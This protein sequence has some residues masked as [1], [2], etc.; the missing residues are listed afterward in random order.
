MAVQTFRHAPMLSPSGDH[1]PDRLLAIPYNAAL[2][3]H[4][5]AR[6]MPGRSISLDNRF[7]SLTAIRKRDPGWQW[8]SALVARSALVRLDRAMQGFFSRVRPG[9]E[10][11]F[12][13]FRARSRYRSLSVDVP[14][15][16]GSALR[17]R[18]GG[19]RG[20]L[21]GRDLPRI[22]FG[23]RQPLR[24]PVRL[25]GFRAVCEARRV[26]IQLSFE[27]VLPTVRTGAPERPLG[28][29]AGTQSHATLSDGGGVERQRKPAVRVA[30]GR[31]QR[32]LSQKWRD[33]KGRGAKKAAPAR[34]HQR[35]AESGRQQFH[36]R[37]DQA[38]KC[39]DSIAAEPLRIRYTIRNTIRSDENERGLKRAP[40]EEGRG[41]FFDTLNCKDAYAGTPFVEVPPPG[42]SE[43]CSRCG[44]RVP[45]ALS[46]RVHRCGGCG[47]EMDRDES[48][49]RN[50][51]SPGRRMFEEAMAAGGTAE[52]A[53]AASAAC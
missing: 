23:V 17:I 16:A 19:R 2:E 26:E 10:S 4:I 41:E 18:D 12:P 20:A 37:T 35:V 27:R 5:R 33:S 49:A 51:L 53:P 15:A 47:L 52:R 40:A 45:K 36:R 38:V 39:G 31:K 46:E 8:I 7:P 14:K 6:R 11:G 42:T 1:L 29:D 34:A 24:R 48:A 32:A 3:E 21:L 44:T 25:R 28:P 9:R 22:G 43:V 13:R 30:L 50:V